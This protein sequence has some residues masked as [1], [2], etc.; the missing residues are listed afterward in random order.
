MNMLDQVDDNDAFD[1]NRTQT[2]TGRYYRHALSIAA[3]L[4]RQD[5]IHK[6]K[7]RRVVESCGF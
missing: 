6:K 7:E 5:D 3:T 4:R 2:A 1:V